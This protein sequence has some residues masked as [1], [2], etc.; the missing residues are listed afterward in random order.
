MD[1]E[2]KDL[3]EGGATEE[4]ENPEED[5]QDNE[6][7][8]DEETELQ[9]KNDGLEDEDI[10]KLASSKAF[11]KL[12]KKTKNAE[13]LSTQYEKD[14]SDLKRR[15]SVL[16]KKQDEFI[17]A[18]KDN[19]DNDNRNKAMS[20]SERQLDNLNKELDIA[21]DDSDYVKIKTL[22]RK[23]IK[24]EGEIDESAKVPE[25]KK[26]VVDDDR[27]AEHKWIRE[28]AWINSNSE[29][30]NKQKYLEAR[31]ELDMMENDPA[32]NGASQVEA[33]EEAKKRVFKST[34]TNYTQGSNRRT[35][36]ENPNKDKLTDFQKNAF[37]QMGVNENDL[38]IKKKKI[39]N[40]KTEY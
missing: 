15:M 1:S 10:K 3:V 4:S 2:L 35:N 14:N 19:I 29:H 17:N 38:K 36:K 12:Y 40:F 30:F 37:E 8:I 32:W 9:L 24:V 25:K 20:R 23:I 7:I 13:R 11:N 16:M 28:N 22:M 34:N 18:Q 39:S 31:Y 6:N 5:S 26:E 21:T 33:Y 27:Q